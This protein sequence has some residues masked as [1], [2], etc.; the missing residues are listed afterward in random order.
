MILKNYLKPFILGCLA[1][2]AAQNA[3]A[4]Q[5]QSFSQ[6][7]LN[8]FLFNPAIAGTQGYT[9]FQSVYRK[10]WVGVE[11]AP[12]T[13][14]AYIQ[15]P[16]KSKAG[17][18][19]LGANIY[20]DKAGA[21]MRNGL[22][23]TYAQHWQLQDNA[24]FS[25]GLTGTVEQYALDKVLLAKSLDAGD[26]LLAGKDS[27]IG[28]DAGF[29]AIVYGDRWSV[30]G[31]ANNLIGSKIDFFDNSQAKRFR[32]Y[33]LMAQRE[34]DFDEDGDLSILPAVLLK[35]TAHTPV[36][37]DMNVSIIHQGNRWVG[38][39]YRTN[40]THSLSANVGLFVKEK[41]VIGYA[42]DM[43]NGKQNQFNA[44]QNSSHEVTLGLRFYKEDDR[45]KALRCPLL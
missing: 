29:S 39:S 45:D 12:E 2:V 8:S 42:Y 23:A 30:G 38:I 44:G 27:K 43:V 35:T 10:Q 3:T 21:I 37:L 26:P 6:Y 41:I 34:F 31:F 18:V 33:Y 32:H 9:S 15:G 36:Q 4:Q 13:F 17:N 20:G 22:S 5:E 25:L 16:V 11:G 14:S 19:G 1:I 40:Q 24:S 7:H 28:F